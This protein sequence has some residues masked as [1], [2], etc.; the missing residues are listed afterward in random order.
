[1]QYIPHLL[2]IWPSKGHRRRAA[3]LLLAAGLTATAMTAFAVAPAGAAS[4]CDP[5]ADVCSVTPATVQTPLG[6]VTVAVSDAGV[7]TVQ[8]TPTAP[9]TLVAGIPVAYPPGPP[10]L[11]GYARTSITTSCT[12]VNIDTFQASGASAGR[13]ALPNLAIISIHPPGPCRVSING[14]TVVFTPI[15]PP[16]PPC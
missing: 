2:T 13:F 1:V 15:L 8:L 7:V 4:V 9:D 16:G 14:T 5:G 6:P 11:P 10:I 12:T 3:S